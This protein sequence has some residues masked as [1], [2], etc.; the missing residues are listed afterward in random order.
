MSDTNEKTTKEIV[1]NLPN[2][3]IVENFPA[4]ERDMYIQLQEA[5][6][7]PSRLNQERSSPRHI[8]DKLSKVKDKE[9]HKDSKRKVLSYISRKA[10]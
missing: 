5:Q 7:I 2:A 9:N 1:D 6:K 3:I 10:N 8:V 4:L